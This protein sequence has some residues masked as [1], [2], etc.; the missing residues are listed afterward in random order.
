MLARLFY[1]TARAGQLPAIL[2]RVDART[3]TPVVATLLAGTIVLVAALLVSFENLL[4][5]TDAVT[6]GV[7]TL[8][9]LAPWRVQRVTP[10]VAAPITLP[11]WL[12]P[13]ATAFSIG[14]MVGE[15][16]V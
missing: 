12:P 6:L 10:P 15:F 14:L 11:R 7:F 8:V 13:A 16:V 3:Q 4:I 1:G 5:L 2:G 9:D